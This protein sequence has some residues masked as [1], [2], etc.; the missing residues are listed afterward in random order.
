MEMFKYT[1]TMIAALSIS[2]GLAQA[3]KEQAPAFR[4]TSLDGKTYTNQNLKG[5]VVLIDFW[6]TWCGPCRQVSKIVQ[7]LQTKYG[8]KGL[9]ILCLDVKEPSPAK[10][11]VVKYKSSHGYTYPFSVANGEFDKTMGVSTLPTVVV[12]GRTGQ[13]EYRHTSLTGLA[14][15][16]EQAVVK[17]LKG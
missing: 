15:E 7:G 14:T 6:A 9:Q 4:I 3:A 10:D 2:V 13:I 11:A 17:A 1:L 8:K 5:K 12:I 16:L